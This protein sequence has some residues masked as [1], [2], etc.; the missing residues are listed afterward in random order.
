MFKKWLAIFKTDSLMDKAYMRSFE[1]LDI[2]MDMCREAKLSLRQ[3]E[4]N[5]IDLTIKEKD[6]CFFKRSRL[7]K[8]P[9]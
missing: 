5:E 1:M 3:R 8:G 4:D 9:G 2:T 6:K 7:G